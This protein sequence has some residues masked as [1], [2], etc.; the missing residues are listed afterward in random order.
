MA[1]VGHVMVLV[2][3]FSTEKLLSLEMFNFSFKLRTL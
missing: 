1:S 2:I 3:V